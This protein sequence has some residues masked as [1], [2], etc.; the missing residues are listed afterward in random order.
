M[1]KLIFITLITILLISCSNQTVDVEKSE[2]SNETEANEIITEPEIFKY[3][4]IN[5]DFGGYEFTVITRGDEAHAYAHHTRD[6]FAEKETGEPIND[7]VY[8]RNM[9]VEEMFNVKIVM[10]QLPEDDENRPNAAVQ[11]AFLAGD[12]I[13]DLLLT[14]QILGGTTALNGY[15][16]NWETVPY[17]DLSK[18]WWDQNAR[19]NLSVGNKLFLALSDFSITSNDRI[20]MI[21]FNKQLKENYKVENLYDVVTAGK[22]TFDKLYEVSKDV[23]EDINGDGVMDEN[24]LYG[25]S[26]AGW[27]TGLFYCAGNTITKKDADNIPYLDML[28]ERAV[29]TYEKSFALCTADSTYHK[30]KDIELMFKENR[31]LILL[32]SLEGLNQYRAMEVDFGIIPSPKLDEA[33][34]KYYAYFSG[35]ASMMGV[36]AAVQETETVGAVIEALSYYSTVYLL[37]AYYDVTLKTKFTRDAESEVMLDLIKDARVFDFGFM[38]DNWIIALQFYTLLSAERSDFVSTIEKNLPAS[39]KNLDNVLATYAQ[40]N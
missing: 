25:F 28:T 12:D 3:L 2:N 8:L 29:S 36:P 34:E 10:I 31:A 6:I 30:T 23:K 19:Y 15:L 13:Y 17:V 21:L 38:Y 33:Q 14:H 40:T 39:Q 27:E 22:W 35:H 18:P 20:N 7:A 4:P 26:V 9:I 5:S 32:T 1:N 24:D 11:K 37:P 16:K